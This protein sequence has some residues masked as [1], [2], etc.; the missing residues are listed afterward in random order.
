MPVAAMLS[1]TRAT[2]VLTSNRAAARH[3]RTGASWEAG[4]GQAPA[5]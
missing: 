2:S 1:G 5:A 3:R 4:N